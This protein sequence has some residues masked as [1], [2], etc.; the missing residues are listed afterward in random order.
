MSFF[1][2][3]VILLQWLW[4]FTL[5]GGQGKGAMR[6]SNSITD[7]PI[8]LRLLLAASKPYWF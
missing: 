8:R 6:E 2:C 3:L 5:R 1:P 4:L 7:I